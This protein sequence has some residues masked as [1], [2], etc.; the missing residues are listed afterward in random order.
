MLTTVRFLHY[1]SGIAWVGASL[2]LAI[3]V[4]PAIDRCPGQVRGPVMRAIARRIAPWEVISALSVIL[5]GGLQVVLDHRLDGGLGPLLSARWG[6]AIGVGL[7]CAIAVLFLGYHVLAPTTYKFVALEES[8]SADPV[9]SAMSIRELG[10]ADAEWW[11]TRQRLVVATTA[12]IA[13]AMVAVACMA[14]ARGS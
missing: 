10:R 13:I 8:V 5:T 11:S 12:E 6:Q 3:I 2:V 14:V 1:V 7:L 4:F 9:R